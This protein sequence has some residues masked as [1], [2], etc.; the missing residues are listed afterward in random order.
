MTEVNN[1]KRYIGRKFSLQAYKEAGTQPASIPDWAINCDGA[2]VYRDEYGFLRMDAVL[3]DESGEMITGCACLKAWT[4]E[5]EQYNNTITIKDEFL[6]ELIDTL[7]KVVADE[8]GDILLMLRIEYAE[9][10]SA[11][12]ACPA[13]GYTKDFL[14]DIVLHAIRRDLLYKNIVHI[15]YLY[16][17]RV[18]GPEVENYEF[19]KS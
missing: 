18:T 14:Y 2:P 9:R 16:G 17:C 15:L 10:L 19:L 7:Q 11:K 5:E 12:A 13:R 3:P 4:V 8:D 6:H 1:E